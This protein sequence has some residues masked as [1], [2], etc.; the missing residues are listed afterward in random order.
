MAQTQAVQ[1]ETKTIRLKRTKPTDLSIRRQARGKGFRYLDADGAPVRDA[2]TLA[3]IRSLAI[4]PAY[5]DVR[6]AADAATPI[7]RPSAMT[8]PAASSIAIIRNGRRSASA[9]AQA[10]GTPDRGAAAAAGGG[11]P[12]PQGP[13]ALARQGAGLRRRR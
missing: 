13:H 11:R 4:P 12:R 6:I 10:A 8:R 2:A 9:Q 3:R 7:S 5:R 1:G